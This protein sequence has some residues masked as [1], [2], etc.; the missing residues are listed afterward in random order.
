MNQG[1]TILRMLGLY[2]FVALNLLQINANGFAAVMPCN[3]VYSGEENRIHKLNRH[4]P[5]DEQVSNK[6]TI[7]EISY[8]FDL[9]GKTVVLPQNSTLKFN[10]GSIKN[11]ILI[12]NDTKIEETKEPVFNKV[13]IS[14]TWCV[15]VIYSTMFYDLSEDNALSNV[16]NLTDDNVNNI[17]IIE[18]SKYDYIVSFSKLYQSVINVRSNTDII[19][20]GRVRVRGNNLNGYRV[21]YGNKK[22]HICFK[23]EGE[24]IGDFYTD[25]EN[26]PIE[27]CHDLSGIQMYNGKELKTHEYCHGICFYNSQYISVIGLKI[28]RFPG[29]AISLSNTGTNN[30]INNHF[31]SGCELFKCRRQGVSIIGNNIIIQDNFIHNINGTNP[32]SAIDIEPNDS[33]CVCS[34]IIIDKNNILDCFRGV[35][36][37]ST[38]GSVSNIR[39]INNTAKVNNTFSY[40]SGKQVYNV[41]VLNNKIESEGISLMY[42]NTNC[43]TIK[44]NTIRSKE[45]AFYNNPGNELMNI[46]NN[47]VNTQKTCLLVSRNST[48]KN[49]IFTLDSPKEGLALYLANSS[50]VIFEHNKVYNGLISASGKRIEINN[51]VISSETKAD[52]AA[53]IW[54]DNLVFNNNSYIIN[55]GASKIPHCV[56]IA[57]SSFA[58]VNNNDFTVADK[59]VDSAIVIE[60][61]SIK[62]SM[63]NNSFKG[64]F[65]NAPIY[66]Q[67]LGDVLIEGT[68]INR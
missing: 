11:G 35:L 54:V 63:K 48:I 31:V 49:N 28:S 37:V 64:E 16:F 39:I 4:K 19:I 18:K 58:E 13:V 34:N 27:G 36:L 45:T 65:V 9:R 3:E 15:P 57:E 40:T 42:V 21:F 32:Q 14:G 29:D 23:G 2:F 44:G 67:S 8:S 59:V 61:K 56:S 22:H 10:G 20:N 51:N 30:I 66:N 46:E 7:Y 43:C 41:E 17:V 24:L 25:D 6:N 26:K 1:Q 38:A 60:N 50:N 12:G 55:K 68:S 5:F 62:M 53:R 47:V 33:T 52:V